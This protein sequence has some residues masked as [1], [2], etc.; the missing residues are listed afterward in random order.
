MA[1]PKTEIDQGN[2]EDLCGLMCTLSE[3]A[4]FFHCSE[5]T[6]ERWCR[7]ELKCSFAEAFKKHSAGGKISL[8]RAQFRLAQKNATM[9]IWLGKQYLGQTDAGSGT[10]ETPDDGFISALKSEAGDAW[11]DRED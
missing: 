7:R 6:I 10:D 9:A 3:I 1:R 4:A 11:A 2:F 5:D 8:R